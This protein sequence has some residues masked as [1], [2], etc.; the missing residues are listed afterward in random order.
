MTRRKLNERFCGLSGHC[1]CVFHAENGWAC[2]HDLEEA[3]KRGLL[4]R[5]ELDALTAEE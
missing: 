1:G 2:E 4:S 3:V 5:E